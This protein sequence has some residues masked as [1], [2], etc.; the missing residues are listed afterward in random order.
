MKYRIGCILAIFLYLILFIPYARIGGLSVIVITGW[1]SISFPWII[2][3][4]IGTLLG[5]ITIPIAL[6]GKLILFLL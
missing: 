6:I 3:L 5:V 1:F 2:N 4:L